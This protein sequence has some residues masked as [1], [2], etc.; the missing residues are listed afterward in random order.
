M[1]CARLPAGSIRPI[2]AGMAIQP[3]SFPIGFR[4]GGSDWQKDTAALV[5]WAKAGGFA[6]IDLGR[7]TKA[8]VN[9][10]ASAGLKLGSVD[11][12]QFDQITHPDAGKRK[13]VIAANVAYVK[14]VAALGAKVFF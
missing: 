7:A 5:S 14:E 2:I 1:T 6:A 13:D 4:R 3:H 10:L 11:L 12:L 9:A 8:D